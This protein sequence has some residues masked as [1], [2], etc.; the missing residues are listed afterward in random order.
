M[1]IGERIY[2]LRTAKNLSQGDLAELVG[3]SRQSISKWENSSAVPD[4]EKIVKLSEI[5]EVSLDKLVKGDETAENMGSKPTETAEKVEYI[6]VVHKQPM[7]GRKIAGII[8]FCMAFLVAFG[9]LFATGS[10]GGIF[11]AFPFIIC[12]I[13]CF[14]VPHHTGLWCAWAVYI[15][16]EFFMRYATGIDVSLVKLTFQYEPSMNYA[17]L[18]TAWIWLAVLIIMVVCTAVRFKNKP[19]ENM[20]KLKKS[21]T[22]LWAVY[23]GVYIVRTV[24][25]KVAWTGVILPFIISHG[26]AYTTIQTVVELVMLAV[27]VVGVT[28]TVRYITAGKKIKSE[29]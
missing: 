17:R 10:L 7:E 24:L 3:V 16:A 27:F 4:L 2:D 26:M 19:V 18:I 5:F 11:Y 28:N 13:I 20:A 12:G 22:I 6:Q 23:I 25:N 14:A 8:L 29:L 21:L 9:I 15:M 1:N